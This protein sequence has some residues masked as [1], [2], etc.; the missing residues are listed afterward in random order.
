MTTLQLNVPDDLE[1]ESLA[2]EAG[3]ETAGANVEALVR[4]DRRKRAEEWMAVEIR[5]GLDSPMSEMNDDARA[6][7]LA[8]YRRSRS[9]ARCGSRR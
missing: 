2:K 6:R 9:D 8:E 4:A 5:K 1:L 3:F 7:V